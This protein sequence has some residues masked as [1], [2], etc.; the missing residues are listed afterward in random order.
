MKE[1]SGES[2]N[3]VFFVL[4][5]VVL[6]G[7][8]TAALR[9]FGVEGANIDKENILLQASQV[10]QY[11]S[12]LERGVGFILRD[13]YSEVD[14]RFAHPDAP[15]GYGSIGS[16]PGRQVFHKDGGGAQYRVPSDMIS[17]ASNWE[18]Y[19]HT[20]LPEVGSDR[21]DLIAVLP[22]VTLA[23]CERIN[24]MNGY[25][26][27][28]QPADP[29]GDCIHSGA[30]TRFSSA[31]LFTASGSANVVDEASFTVK[32]ALQGCVECAGP[33]YHFYHVILAR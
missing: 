1:R 15:A 5:A 12:E 13:S 16:D 21:A 30:S 14:I 20:R 25:D 23:F 9:S 4:L 31:A 33:A 10:R 28:T 11:A 19:G 3:V 17:S 24:K 2:G 22:D 26:P 8:V 18:F 7:L 6:L 29:T 27:A 32:P